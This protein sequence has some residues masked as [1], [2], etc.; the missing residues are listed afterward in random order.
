MFRWICRC[1]IAQSFRV[2]TESHSNVVTLA[3][4]LEVDLGIRTCVLSNVFL[5]H[6]A[7]VE[8]CVTLC[9]TLQPSQP[10]TAAAIFGA[11]K[12]AISR[13]IRPSH[14]R[15]RR[16]FFCWKSHAVQRFSPV[17][18]NNVATCPYKEIWG[19]KLFYALACCCESLMYAQL[20]DVMAL[21]S[22]T[23][24]MD[25]SQNAVSRTCL[26][27]AGLALWGRPGLDLWVSVLGTCQV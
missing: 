9:T 16:T 27:T 13:G 6:H 15:A 11:A 20:A 18:R 25:Y 22:A 19:T 3:S 10:S 1:L 4:S 14:T 21:A 26:S 8:N 24:S 17:L 5:A 2:S 23:E 7:A 12:S